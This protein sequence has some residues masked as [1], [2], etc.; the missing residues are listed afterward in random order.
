MRDEIDTDH[1]AG[2]VAG[3]HIE[4]LAKRFGELVRRHAG[5]DVR[6]TA[7]RKRVDDPDRMT[8]PGFGERRLRTKKRR[9]KC[10]GAKQSNAPAHSAA[11]RWAAAPLAFTTTLIAS[12]TRSLA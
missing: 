9:S 4:L 10:R 2:A 3:L 5:K 6:G 11:T 7:R 1:A 12:S 8:G